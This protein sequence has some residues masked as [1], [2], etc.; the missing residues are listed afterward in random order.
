[1]SCFFCTLSVLIIDI[2]YFDYLGNDFCSTLESAY[3]K[4][5]EDGFLFTF[6]SYY[7]VLFGEFRI[8]ILLLVFVIAKLKSSNDI[9]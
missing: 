7:K 5:R 1:M 6:F 3:Y 4:L 9:L 2:I 8:A